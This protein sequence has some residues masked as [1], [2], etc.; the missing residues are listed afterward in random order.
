LKRVTD[1]H[2]ADGRDIVYRIGRPRSADEPRG[3]DVGELWL[4]GKSAG[5]PVLT[6]EAPLTGRVFG[7]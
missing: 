5:E 6:A 4:L 1:V 3:G 2:L 7:K